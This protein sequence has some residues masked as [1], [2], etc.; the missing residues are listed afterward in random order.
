[1]LRVGR[2]HTDYLLNLLAE[3]QKVFTCHGGILNKQIY[4]NVPFAG[5]KKHSHTDH[6]TFAL[7]DQQ[8]T[9][10]KVPQQFQ[11]HDEES[12]AAAVSV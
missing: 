1:M 7:N 4:D 2:R 11:A 9:S 12:A 8:R 10:S 6:C 5:F 3:L